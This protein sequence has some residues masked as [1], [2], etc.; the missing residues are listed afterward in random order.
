MDDEEIEESDEGAGMRPVR[1]A[2]EACGYAWRAE[3]E[4]AQQEQAEARARALA[5]PG[6]PGALHPEYLMAVL[7][8]VLGPNDVVV[9]D[10]GNAAVWLRAQYEAG[11]T[12][13]FI[14]TTNFSAVGSGLPVAIG[15]RA[16]LSEDEARAAEAGA[17]AG[18]GA[19]RVVAVT[20]DGGFMLNVAELETSVRERLPVVAVIANDFG[21]GNVRSYQRTVYGDRR[22]ASDLTNPDFAAL[23]RLFGADGYR[24]ERPDELAPALQAA[25]AGGRTA[26][27]D[28]L[29]DPEVLCPPLHAAR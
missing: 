20:G 9:S 6:G 16:G 13:G 10:S 14:D 28:V 19:G 27:V 4:A 3:V 5:N 12:S 23:A 26:V 17:P 22:I 8:G 25:L 24:V 7:S 15:V 2:C 11:L 1:Y 21:F 29:V 18:F